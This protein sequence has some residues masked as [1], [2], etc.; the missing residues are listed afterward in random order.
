VL[1]AR[2]VSPHRG[3]AREAEQ[4]VGVA[5]VERQSLLELRHGLVQVAGP[6]VDARQVVVDLG[7]RL[8]RRLAFGA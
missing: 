3:D 1:G 8:G 2:A 6:R 7:R 4:C 5:G